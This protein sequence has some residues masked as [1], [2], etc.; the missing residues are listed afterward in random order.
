VIDAG[1]DSVLQMLPVF[2]ERNRL[3]PRGAGDAGER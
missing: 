2:G 3:C 1:I